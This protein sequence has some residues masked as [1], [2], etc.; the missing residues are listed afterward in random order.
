MNKSYLNI[1]F[2]T[3]YLKNHSQIKKEYPHKNELS[4][5][6]VVLVHV[7]V[8]SYFPDITSISNFMPSPLDFIPTYANHTFLLQST[9]I[10]SNSCKL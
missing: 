8:G 9:A 6:H 7:H 4:F 5:G 1:I 3:S 2:F 10:S